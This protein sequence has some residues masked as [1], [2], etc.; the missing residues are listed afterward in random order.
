MACGNEEEMK[1]YMT[2]YQS[3]QYLLHHGKTLHPETF[4]KEYFEYKEMKSYRFSI[5]T[6]II[7]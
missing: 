7:V 3:M 6:H 1:K 5:G 4:L 2:S